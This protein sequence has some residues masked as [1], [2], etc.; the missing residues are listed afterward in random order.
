M[1]HKIILIPPDQT[2]TSEQWQDIKE[3]SHLPDE[4]R[5]QIEQAIIFYRICKS[6]I[7]GKSPAQIKKNLKNL[8]IQ[9]KKLDASLKDLADQTLAMVVLSSIQNPQTI[10]PYN[11]A[12][13]SERIA[14]LQRHLADL[15]DW[16]QDGHNKLGNWRPGAGQRKILLTLFIHSLDGIYLEFR[17]EHIKRTTKEKANATDYIRAVCRVADPKIG[18]GSID[19]AMKTIITAHGETR[20]QFMR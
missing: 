11:P 19:E 1:I 12:S 4:A 15:S 5:D 13:A 7:G 8:T 16:I 2:L 10:Q 9:A 17:G 20:A 6:T 18:N 14:E 3:K